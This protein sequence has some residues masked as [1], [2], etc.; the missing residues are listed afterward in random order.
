MNTLDQLVY[1][2]RARLPH[3]QAAAQIA[4]IVHVSAFRNA[5]VGVTGALALKGEVFVQMLEGSPTALDILML[6]LHFDARH[7][8]IVVLARERIT[9][10]A[11]PIWGMIAP[12][13]D[14]AA[15]SPLDRLIVERS[16][17][18]DLWRQA[19]QTEELGDGGVI[20][21]FSTCSRQA[22]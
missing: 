14:P 9:S 21:R 3:E 5:Q 18:L 17:R 6:H 1:C 12:Q 2:S 15:P 22:V 13:R 7:D 16:S 20:S 8:D 4:D 19:L 10:R 11:F